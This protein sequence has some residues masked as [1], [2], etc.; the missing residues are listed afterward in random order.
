MR[1]LIA[2]LL[3]AVLAW[4]ENFRL[5]LKDGTHHVVREYQV[6]QDRVR[7]YSVERSDWEDLPLELVDLKKT[8]GERRNRVEE[9]KK[10]AAVEDAEEKFDR[11][12]AREVSSIP[13]SPGVYFVREGKVVEIKLAEVKA[14][15]NK[16]RSILKAM[17]PIPIVAGKAVLEVSGEHAALAVPSNKPEL[18]FRIDN[19]ARFSIVR[20]KPRKAARQVAIWNLE[21]VSKQV[22]F[23]MEQVEVFRQQ[24]R[25]NLY[26][27]WPAKTLAPGEYALV[28]YVEG[29]GQI[30][31]WDFRVEDGS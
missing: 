1:V 26:K 28:Q 2:V 15:T 19:L 22:F 25:D 29:D 16:K 9:E 10:Q 3:L 31:A 21:P 5:Y 24:V 23:D 20:M 8:E 11:E 17:S 30:Q 18:Y 6:R 27:V 7:Y 13:E 14:Q 12:M 4:A